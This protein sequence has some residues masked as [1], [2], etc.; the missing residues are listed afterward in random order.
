QFEMAA[1]AR[2]KLSEADRRDFYLFIDEFQNFS[3][4]A[5]ASILAESR[6]YRLCLTLS[7]QYIDQ[8]SLPVRQSVFGNVGTLIA[9]RVG[10]TDAQGPQ[11]ELGHDFP[12]QQFVDLGSFETLVR[13]L[14]NGENK[15]PFRA[16]TLAPMENRIGRK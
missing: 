3:T 10:H 6:K 2:A 7:H 11:K 16:R 5:F 4:E 1:M 15:P 14:E 9:F 13:L 8:L 12:A